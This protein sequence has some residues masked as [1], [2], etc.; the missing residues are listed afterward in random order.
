MTTTPRRARCVLTLSVLV[1][2]ACAPTSGGGTTDPGTTDPGATDP[3]T[4]GPATPADPATTASAAPATTEPA[5]ADPTTTEQSRTLLEVSIRADESA[6]PE[7]Y[8]LECLDGAPGPASTLPDA[9]AAC[10]DVAELGAEFFIAERD[11][12]LACTQQYG[13]PQTAHVLGT[14][15]G[16]AVDTEFSR[17]DGC[18]ISRWDAVQSLLGPGGVDLPPESAGPGRP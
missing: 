6:A 8:V 15:D 17:T 5:P 12:D 3:G 2:T 1:L 13:G 7:E 9:E 10:A 4:T 14:V 11:P 16:E 18:E